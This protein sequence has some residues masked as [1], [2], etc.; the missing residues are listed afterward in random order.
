MPV[1]AA[2]VSLPSCMLSR[3]YL[4]PTVSDFNA[5]TPHTFEWRWAS[6]HLCDALFSVHATFR[7]HAATLSSCTIFEFIAQTNSH[8]RRDQHT[9]T[10]IHIHG[11]QSIV[12]SELAMGRGGEISAPRKQPIRGLKEFVETCTQVRCS[13]SSYEHTQTS[14]FVYSTCAVFSTMVHARI[15]WRN[16]VVLPS[17]FTDDILSRSPLCRNRQ[18]RSLLKR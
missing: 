14:T 1:S 18:L 5:L 10:Y 12:V 16:H 15:I 11:R 9:H 7:S 3:A 17:T 2:S 6:I 8:T 4:L 13:S